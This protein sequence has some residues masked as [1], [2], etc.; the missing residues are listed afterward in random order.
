VFNAT[1]NKNFSYIV[2][3]SFI[4]GGIWSTWRNVLRLTVAIETGAIFL[5]QVR[6]SL[7]L[8]WSKI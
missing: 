5:V 2:A 7:K 8:F 4:G 3:V 6:L 1:F